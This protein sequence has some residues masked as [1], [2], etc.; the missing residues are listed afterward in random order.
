MG[1]ATDDVTDRLFDPPAAGQRSDGA[2]AVPDRGDD[3]DCWAAWTDTG[4]E[5]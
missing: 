3:A 5:G 4:G 2:D 1:D